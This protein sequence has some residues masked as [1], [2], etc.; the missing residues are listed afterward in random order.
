[1]RQKQTHC[2]KADNGHQ[3]QNRIGPN[4][5]INAPRKAAC[6]F[7]TK[8][9]GVILHFILK[10]GKPQATHLSAL[11]EAFGEPTPKLACQLL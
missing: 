7:F 3:I 8:S 5:L 1:M 11:A 10:R 9:T 6:E 2:R 4:W